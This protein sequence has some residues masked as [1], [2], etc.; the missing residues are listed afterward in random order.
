MM[1]AILQVQTMKKR[2]VLLLDAVL[3]QE[4]MVKTGMAMLDRAEGSEEMELVDSKIL[5]GMENDRS[6]V[7]QSKV[8]YMVTYPML[9][10]AA[11]IFL[12]IFPVPCV[13]NEG[14]L[15]SILASPSSAGVHPNQSSAQQGV[16]QAPT[17]K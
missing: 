12:F 11:I 13:T 2:M 14:G 10:G 4:G 1:S 16:V 6:I 15:L 17:A 7:D 5:P 3:V 8:V 9:S